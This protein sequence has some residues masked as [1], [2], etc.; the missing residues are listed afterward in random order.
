M[1]GIF[2]NVGVFTLGDS[3]TMQLNGNISTF[4]LGENSA[5][6][7][8]QDSA[9]VYEYGETT[10]DV[11][12]NDSDPEGD[13]LTVISAMA[14]NGSAYVTEFNTINYTASFAGIDTI[15]Y[16]VQDVFGNTAQSF[17]I[18][19]VLGD[20]GGGGGGFNNT[21]VANDDFAITDEHSP[22]SINV[23]ENDVDFDGDNL[24]LDPNSITVLS[25]DVY[26]ISVDGNVITVMP[27]D[28]AGQ[29]DIQVS[30]SVTDGISSSTATLNV[31]VTP[32]GGGNTPPVANSD[33]ATTLINQSITVNVLANDTDAD[34]DSLVLSQIYVSPEVGQVVV[35]E[36]NT[37]TFTPNAGFLGQAEIQYSIQDSSGA[38]ASASLF[39]NVQTGLLIEGTEA[40][41]DF[42][43]TLGSD[44][45]YGF[46]GDDII[47]ADG[48]TGNLDDIGDIL[49]GG[50]GNDFL[51]GG[52]GNDTYIFNLGDGQDEINNFDPNQFTNGVQ[53][54]DRLLFGIG[55][56]AA[57]VQISISNH[58]FYGTEMVTLS[59]E[60][61]NDSIS[62]F[63]GFDGTGYSLQDVMLDTI[64][65][66]DGTVWTKDHILQFDTPEN[67]N[68]APMAHNDQAQ[69]KSNQ[70]IIIN[71]LENDS[72]PEG[73]ALT[74]IS[75][76]ANQGTVSINPDNT[77]SYSA[78]FVGSEIIRYTIQDTF[79]NTSQAFV[80]MEV[81]L[82]NQA[83]IAN[84]DQTMAILNK[85]TTINVL[86][87]DYDPDGD[88]LTVVSAIASQGVVSI[89]LDNT[90]SYTANF[91]GAD[92]VV[93]FVKDTFGNSSQSAVLVNVIP[94]GNQAP[95]ANNDQATVGRN[96][97]ITI[98]VLA[99]DFDL[100]G[101][102]LVLTQASISPDIG[103][104]VINPD[105][106][107]TF[108]P[109]QGFIG[110]AEIQYAIA[111][112]ASATA[113]ATL[114]VDVKVGLT[115]TGDSNDNVL[116]GGVGDDVLIGLEGDDYLIGQPNSSSNLSDYII[117]GNDVLIG[118]T[119]NDFLVGL[120][121]DDTYIFNLSDGQDTINNMDPKQ[122]LTGAQS[123]DRL[124]F[125]AGITPNNITISFYNDV[126]GREFVKFSIQGTTDSV[127][128]SGW[129]GGVNAPL[130]DAIIDEVWFTDGTV[131]TKDYILNP[132]IS[133]DIVGDDDKNVLLGTLVGERVVGLA[134]SDLLFGN[135]G[136]DTLIGGL[137][138]DTLGGGQGQDVYVFNLGDGQDV[139][140][141]HE[142]DL[143]NTQPSLDILRFG[144]G[145]KPQDIEFTFSGVPFSD[146]LIIK[147]KGSSDQITVEHYFNAAL[148][149]QLAAIE[150]VDG[151]VWGQAQITEQIN[152]APMLTNKQAV[153]VHGTEDI[154]Y[155]IQASDLLQGF[156]D[157]NGDVLHLVGLTANNSELIDNQNGT[158]SLIPYDNFNGEI[159]LTYQ[160][161]DGK[162]GV[163][164]AHQRVFLNAV[165][166]LPVVSANTTP[167]Y[168]IEDTPT[169]ILVA[170]L[171]QEL[172]DVD[173]DNLSLI[174]LQT[175]KG[176][177]VNNQ[178]GTFSLTTNTNFNGVVHLNYQ[179]GD[180]HTGVVRVSKNLI[181]NAVNDAPVLTTKQATLAHG[182]EDTDYVIN[183]RDLLQGFSDIDDDALS[184]VN[185][186]VNDGVLIDNQNGTYTFSPSWN[187][188]GK[189]ELTYLVDDGQ[190]S[191][192]AT[193]SFMIDAVDDLP[194]LDLPPTLYS[195]LEDT[196]YTLS[197]SEFIG[198]YVDYDDELVI[199]HVSVSHGSFVANQN[200]TYTF[201]PPENYFGGVD[202]LFSISSG[203]SSALMSHPFY[204]DDI[205]DSPMLIDGSIVL[206]NASNR[207]V[208]TLYDKDLLQGFKDV[209]GDSLSI[210][211]LSTDKGMFINYLNGSYELIADFN[212]SGM[213]NLSYQVSDGRGGI[214]DATQH[215]MYDVINS[216][217][218]GFV[219][220]IPIDIDEDGSFDFGSGL[221][222]G[223]LTDPD[224][225]I[226]TISNLHADTGEVIAHADGT[227]T[228]TALKD[229]TGFTGLTYQ[230]SDGRGSVVS[231]SLMIKVHPINDAPTGQATAIL[232]EGVQGT[233]Y[234]IKTKD[235]L[236]GFSDVDG[237]VLDIANVYYH[238]GTLSSDSAVIQNNH[239]GTYTITPDDYVADE[240]ELIY[241]VIDGQGGAIEAYKT[242]FFKSIVN[243]TGTTGAD[244][245][246]GSQND[247]VFVVNHARDMIVEPVSGGIDTLEASVSYILPT[248]I[249][250]LTLVG[251]ANLSGT[252]NST[253][254]T[255]TGNSGKNR[256]SAGDGNDV[257]YGFAGSDTLDGGLGA[258]TLF[259]GLGSDVF[260]VDNI[261]DVVVELL[262]QG[263]DSVNSWVSYTL[264]ANVERL[265]LEG[266]D[267]I[268]GIGNELDNI[269]NGN[270]GNNHLLGG[271]GDD[272]LE[273]KGGKDTLE[274]GLG[275][276]IY[277]IDNIND[278]VVEQ[279]DAGIDK[280]S[281]S[282]N[283]SLSNHVEQLFLTGSGNTAATG[284]NLDNIIYGNDGHNLLLGA[285]GNDSLNGGMGNDTLDGGAGNDTLVGGLSD[286]IYL[287]GLNSG[288]DIINNMDALGN[289]KVLF[290]AGI[291]AEQ[292]W[293]R[294]LGDDLEVS[295]IGTAN[296][297][298]I[299]DW[300]SG[301]A[302]K[303]IDSLQLATGNTLLENE[304]QTLV[305]AMAAFAPPPLGQTSLSATQ[306]ASLGFAIAVAWEITS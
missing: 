69:T 97:P 116:Y 266:V 253:N 144:A 59:I 223:G 95:I 120:S 260:I 81:L 105:N 63:G 176:Y 301:D 60:G 173:G 143:S 269:I 40:D 109:N 166:D 113:Q 222:L 278:V 204:V 198:V 167:V 298:K 39:V 114:T 135:E 145:I 55:I 228:F 261:G 191:I 163:I 277:Y 210:L 43:A 187:F 128:I 136:D 153:L 177:L 217:I 245:L 263:F 16:T 20:T 271:L 243:T 140:N 230:V 156:S 241:Q 171:L 70:P 115:L 99:N 231:E 165:N 132:T 209:D 236:Q 13:N 104:V 302:T 276:D 62:I 35:N 193:Q 66:A 279:A 85:P 139:I 254:N 51:V 238:V 94:N 251:M 154:A 188:N 249:E 118:G 155:L 216:E 117:D 297:I 149:N 98:N 88:V 274:G 242:I 240:V 14:N 160:V 79:G 295:I 89:N 78:N 44:T 286:D 46:G 29:Q 68:N 36:D 5:P 107:V 3:D 213:V 142:D 31:T 288:R 219:L 25:G 124:F 131:W 170:D 189:V 199:S 82:G 127:A 61:S 275:D 282:V 58:P 183:T 215:F 152:H 201:T 125:G 270:S 200:G 227:Y 284:N 108:T 121:G 164:A 42:I 174:D 12:W 73:D 91:V 229:F 111:D 194:W 45:I 134:G 54:I 15:T 30:Y 41:D 178:N 169:L 146:D 26:D 64:E 77:L 92:V 7:P 267:S 268:N 291:Q 67:T 150:F 304:V 289:D 214:I 103:Q 239:N 186:S 225:D 28:L 57:A 158:F 218:E 6:T 161:S 248:N 294:Q 203:A 300:Y 72:D 112:Y 195:A 281:S 53:S 126:F 56:T 257:L 90:L 220:P 137:G 141:T 110:Q 52:S 196:S 237:D 151:T 4:N 84:M 235:L 280:V 157:A 258:D 252:G 232:A 305:N 206:A 159:A 202:I 296:S 27:S 83:P 292:V 38:S 205:N 129:F 80:F 47:V 259:G 287:F 34:N 244:S 211:N 37:V 48:N 86:A 246:H 1:S 50:T 49:V 175:D 226:L 256:L 93:Y 293:L 148:T 122:L 185:L 197:L 71:V 96:Q 172:T 283:Y 76:V 208:Y 23:I 190:N 262:Q 2:I 123:T 119:G 10:I 133:G 192:D 233:P 65:F 74:V 130:V 221:L 272:T 250:N 182:T 9:S 303:R 306:Q 87:N 247:D 265:N 106:T 207:A 17:V 11:L 18:V 22:V 273:G 184:V 168:G 33:N 181:I 21:P 285:E 138:N 19:D 290:D 264:T 179:V 32:T 299:Q 75:A 147:V 162:G 8:Q 24:S 102:T 255:L 224:G 180:N 100:D 212:M 101:D 234:I